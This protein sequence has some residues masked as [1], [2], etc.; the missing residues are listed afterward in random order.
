MV[1]VVVVILAWVPFRSADLGEAVTLWRS[2]FGLQGL[3]SVSAYPSMAALVAIGVASLPSN[4]G[5]WR[6]DHFDAKKLA[7]AVIVLMGAVSLG[8][9]R[10]DVS[11]FLYFRF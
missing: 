1:V 7:F 10:L 4:S 6:R 5:G 9:G 2:M 8:Y 3:G 11:P